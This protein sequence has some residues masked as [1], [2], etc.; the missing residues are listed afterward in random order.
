MGFVGKRCFLTGFPMKVSDSKPVTKN[1]Q[2]LY[3]SF[4]QC[5]LGL[6]GKKWIETFFARPQGLPVPK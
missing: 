5:S 2:P 4:S 1:N 3:W 6:P